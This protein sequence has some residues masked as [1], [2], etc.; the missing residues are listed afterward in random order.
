MKYTETIGIVGGMGSYATLDFFRRILDAF[1]AEKE[2]DRPRIVIDNRCT[3]PSRVR[4][5][6]YQ[7]EKET[8]VKEMEDAVR[9]LLSCGAD[10]LVFGCNTS[11]VFIPDV[12]RS[13]P[14][15]GS[16]TVHI[17]EALA[18]RLKERGVASAY[19]LASEGTIESRIYQKTFSRFGITLD[20]PALEDCGSIRE[21]I[22]IVKQNQNVESAKP[23]FYDFCE[24][25]PYENIILGCTELPVLL[26]AGELKSGK[27]LWD[28]LDAAIEYIKS[29]IQ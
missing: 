25:I 18:R 1:P 3:M 11:H 2:W 10:H 5:I 17:I 7:E 21:Y 9:G 6:L 16:K 22:E 19:L 14:E 24:A 20:A 15:A 27:K 23:R 12:F 29:I 8:I 26:P 13:I 28:P 4:A